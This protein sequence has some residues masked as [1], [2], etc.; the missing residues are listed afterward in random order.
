MARSTG[1]ILA[2]GGVTL[3]NKVILNGQPMDWRIPIA[4]GLAAGAFALFERGWEEGAVGL[5]WLA[6]MV[7]IL[8]PIDPST[9]SPIQALEKFVKGQR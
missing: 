1:P 7:T 9:P 2:V 6:L 8:I 3:A 4:T 5:A